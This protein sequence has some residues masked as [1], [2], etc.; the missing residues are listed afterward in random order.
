MS[1]LVFVTGD[2]C[3]G[4]TLVSTLFRKSGQYYCLYEPLHERLPEF[5]IWRPDPRPHDHHFFAADNYGEMAEF[6]RITD[7]HSR[8]WGSSNFYLPPD[9]EDDEL[10]RYMMY[11]IGTSFGRRPRVMFK[12]NRIA[13][14][15][16]WIRA[17]FPSAKIVHIFR[18]AESQWNSNVRRVQEFLRKDDVGQTSTAYNGF[19]VATYCEDLKSTFPELDAGNFRSGYQRFH[20]LWELSYVENQKYSDISVDYRD[21]TRDFVPTWARVWAN[22]GA[23][24]IDFTVL[25]QYVVPPE[26]QKDFVKDRSQL[27]RYAHAMIDR[28]GI[29]YAKVRLR[30]RNA[31]KKTRTPDNP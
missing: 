31:L 27:G 24:P 11:V 1:N 2:F 14:R 17:K 12:E 15:L 10:Y 25:K 28:V 5:L 19:N 8:K 16:G 26:K 22:I 18:D 4:S 20:R 30:S 29:R 21:L 6:D 3:S 23:S 7:L 9:A 13:F